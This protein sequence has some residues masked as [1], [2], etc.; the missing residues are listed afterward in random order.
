MLH[1]LDPQ[2]YADVYPLMGDMPDY[3]VPLCDLLND[4]RPGKVYVDDVENP[5]SVF[6]YSGAWCYLGGNPAN[7]EFNQAVHRLIMAPEFK[8]VAY[9]GLPEML[10]LNCDAAWEEPFSVIF[11]NRTPI[12][13][14][15]KHYVFDTLP[16]AWEDAVPDGYEIRQLDEAL[17]EDETFK[18]REQIERWIEMTWTGNRQGFFDRGAG[19]CTLKGDE[20]TCW[21]LTVAIAGD[22]CELGIETQEDHHRKGLG[23]LTAMAMADLCL[24]AG[25]ST[26]DWHCDAVNFGSWGVAERAGFIPQRD[27]TSYLYFFDPVTHFAVAGNFQLLEKD[28]DTALSWYQKALTTNPDAPDWVCFMIARAYAGLG[29]HQEALGYLNTAIDKGWV[30]RASLEDSEEFAA[31]RDTPEW[32]GVLAQMQEKIEGVVAEHELNPEWDGD[33]GAMDDFP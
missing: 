11:F 5:G 9:R 6:M 1:E 23:T 3:H 10:F 14:A 20:I 17:L 27:Y 16:Y 18:N 28:Y 32:E 15:R 2:N 8:D 25:F 29:A 21:C 24:Q 26:I 22:T 7:A 4:T 30:K 12:G 31:L 33:F 13:V 19:V